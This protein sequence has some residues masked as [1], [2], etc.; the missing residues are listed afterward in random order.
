MVQY[1]FVP[2]SYVLDDSVTTAIHPSVNL[3]SDDGGALSGDSKYLTFK[4]T[5]PFKFSFE[6][7][8]Q[9]IFRTTFTSPNHALPPHRSVPILE[10]GLDGI[11]IAQKLYSE[12][13][14]I[15]AGD[16]IVSVQW[17][18]TPV[19]SISYK[20]SDK[21]L[22]EDLPFRSYCVDGPG[23][24]H[25]TRF[26]K[27]TL[28]VGLGEKAAPMN[29]NNRG[30]EIS[31]TDSFGY[32]VY[33]T[34][35]LYK[36]IPLLINA[37]PYGCVATFSTSHC[38]GR[39]AVGSEMDGLWGYYKT[40]R[41]AHGGL[42]EYVIVGKNL[43]EVVRTFA[44]LVGYPQLVPRWAFGYI[45]GGMKYSMLD[46]PRAADA[47]MEWA[48]KVKDNNIPCSGFQLSSGYTVA[49]EEP[50]TRNVFTWNKHRF[51]DPE[52]WIQAFHK[53]GI[54][55]IA[56]V[57]PYVLENHPAYPSL[58]KAGALFYDPVRGASAKMRLWSAG[59]G[60]SGE[61][62]HIDFTSS[63]GFRWWYEGVKQLKSEGIDC[64]WNDNNEYT[65][66]SD[67][68]QLKLDEAS[69]RSDN[70]LKRLNNRV[71]WWGRA[72]HTELMGK[73]S[74]DACLEVNPKERPFVLTRS[75]TIGTMRY[76]C[77]SWSGDN[78]TSWD[79]MK[80]A[81]ALSLNAGICLL[82]CYG[83]DIGGFEGPQPSPELLLRWVQLGIYSPRF[84]IN[85]Y[86]TSPADNTVGDVIEPW[87]YP[88]IVPEVR[89]AIKTRYKLIPYLYSLHSESHL[90]AIPPQRWVG[91][92]YETDPEVWTN[93]KLTD[94]EE[95]YWLGD[96]LLIGGVYEPGV[97]KAKMYL[98]K[99]EGETEGYYN[100]NEPF[101]YLQ[102]GQWVDIHSA[103]KASIPVLAKAGTILIGGRPEQT[104][105]PSDTKNEAELPEDD[106]R[107]VAAFP[108]P[109]S[110]NGKA[111]TSTWYDD[112]GISLKP[113]ISK[114]HFAM[115][116]T[117]SEIKVSF[118]PDVANVFRPPWLKNA[119][120]IFLPEGDRR[121]VVSDKNV[122]ESA[123]GGSFVGKSTKFWLLSAKNRN[124]DGSMN[125]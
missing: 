94:G 122:V 14:S 117:E 82:Q 102:P 57:K 13:K 47:L 77:S 38:R 10:A 111:Y 64:I 96:S 35:P 78:V 23:I 121:K 53:Q 105:A 45:G 72:L 17:S 83:H 63:A 55:I 20:D 76:A 32:D 37:L 36:H 44:D 2:Q 98:P 6:V 61:G 99:R 71:G 113:N 24:C 87:M 107:Y 19:I 97:T 114:F 60:E 95:Q 80:G 41:Q 112:D 66:P 51:P 116:C 52:G 86:K 12:Q 28:H 123:N 91:W 67:D 101:Q 4:P 8:R 84:A 40:Y 48:K 43:Q 22:F 81:N 27:H 29:L 124:E 16:I 15:A 89:E 118:S 58:R 85:C 3:R 125:W 65:I 74:Y 93:R 104:V 54:H 11:P 115:S 33:R 34:D 120:E 42:E 49:E 30:F 110:S 9:N 79:S 73:S 25:Y 68:W 62:S 50:K 56:N 69:V 26:K 39:Y 7:L 103:W 31:A 119:I 88:E 70:S 108:P 106:H 1:E 109:G 5:S 21:V 46:E 18:N 59:G 75:A 90:F 100:V 92:G